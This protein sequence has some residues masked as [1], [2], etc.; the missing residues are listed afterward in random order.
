MTISGWPDIAREVMMTYNWAW[1]PFISWIIISKFTIL[2]LVIAILCQS[3][4]HVDQSKED[5]STNKNEPSPQHT[6]DQIIRLEEK[7]N[8]LT[9]NMNALMATKQLPSVANA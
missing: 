7:M 8:E 1:I 4:A 6:A 2:Q 9:N 5:K 3:L